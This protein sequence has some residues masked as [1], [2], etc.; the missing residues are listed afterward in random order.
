MALH[1]SGSPPPPL[2]FAGRELPLETIL[3]GKRLA[4]IHHRDFDPIRFG[5]NEYN[6]F[7]DQR[8]DFGVCY[9][10]MNHEGAFAEPTME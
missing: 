8:R 1:S 3:R 5:S 9:L 7:D 2:D 10:A 6:R 4:R